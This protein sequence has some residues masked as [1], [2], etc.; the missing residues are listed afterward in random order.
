MAGFNL[1]HIRDR[2]KMEREITEEM[3]RID[4]QVEIITGPIPQIK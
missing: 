2:E 4:K 3:K 1:S